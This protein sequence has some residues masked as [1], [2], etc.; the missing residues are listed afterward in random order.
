MDVFE[1]VCSRSNVINMTRTRGGI[2]GVHIYA[3]AGVFGARVAYTRTHARTHARTLGT[4][5]ANE[6]EWDLF[7]YNTMVGGSVELACASVCVCIFRTVSSVRL[8]AIYL[9]S[10]CV[11][12]CVLHSLHVLEYVCT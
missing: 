3:K 11:R 6:K 12:A 8:S 4:R 1:C 9:A 7:S 5:T 10:V 2:A